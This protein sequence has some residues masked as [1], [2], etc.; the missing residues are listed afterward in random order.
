MALYPKLKLQIPSSVNA[1]TTFL[2]VT[3]SVMLVTMRN[4]WESNS[5][6]N[7]NPV[8][9]HHS[10]KLSSISHRNDYIEF[11]HFW[12]WKVLT[13]MWV[14]KRKM[15]VPFC[16]MALLRKVCNVGNVRMTLLTLVNDIVIWEWYNTNYK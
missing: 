7:N 1:K 14:G 6:W 15:K 8:S 10:N 12:K 11:L 16:N 4:R 2:Y 9:V 13:E 5:C 3:M